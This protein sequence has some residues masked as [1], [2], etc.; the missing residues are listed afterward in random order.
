MILEMEVDEGQHL[1]LLAERPPDILNHAFKEAKLIAWNELK[2]EAR[3]VVNFGEMYDWLSNT[4]PMD[5]EY[6]T[7]GW[8]GQVIKGVNKFPLDLWNRSNREYMSQKS[9]IGLAFYVAAGHDSPAMTDLRNLAHGV[10][11]LTNDQELTNG[12]LGK[13]RVLAMAAKKCGEGN[14]PP[15][16][17]AE[18][19]ERGQTFGH[20]EN[21]LGVQKK[22]RTDQESASAW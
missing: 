9:W 18:V 5:K 6:V 7:T 4:F 17:S 12:N 22:R 2:G 8:E 20:A 14:F 16:T 15:R 21:P 3:F 11:A 1:S 19:N 10:E 13:K